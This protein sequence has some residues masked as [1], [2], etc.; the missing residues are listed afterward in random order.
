[1]IDW[2]YIVDRLPALGL[3]VVMGWGASTLQDWAVSRF[4]NPDGEKRKA[5]LTFSGVAQFI[6]VVLVAY[7]A[8]VSGKAAN[9]SKDTSN[10]L[11]SAVSCLAVTTFQVNNALV[12]RS[13]GNKRQARA[14]VK[15]QKAFADF[16]AIFQSPKPVDPDVAGQALREYYAALLE[17]ITKVKAQL[18]SVTVNPYPRPDDLINCLHEAGVEITLEPKTQKEDS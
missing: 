8:I 15:L 5:H 3:G 18:N 2:A 9:E 11:T 1:M 4:R 17:F 7:A 12:E 6:I 16:L 10:S 14:N 13:A